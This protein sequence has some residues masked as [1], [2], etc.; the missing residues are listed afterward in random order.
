MIKPRDTFLQ[1]KGHD[2]SLETKTRNFCIIPFV[3]ECLR[4]LGKSMGQTPFKNTS[5]IVSTGGEFNSLLSNKL[6]LQFKCKI[7]FMYFPE[8]VIFFLNF[9]LIVCSGYSLMIHKYCIYKNTDNSLI[10]QISFTW[11]YVIKIQ[12]IVSYIRL[13]SHGSMW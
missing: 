9:N 1:T 12:I 4:N 2:F 13:A 11:I 10:H 7:L 3:F 5:I 6:V 8:V